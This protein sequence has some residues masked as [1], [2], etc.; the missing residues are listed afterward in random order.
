MSED[1]LMMIAMVTGAVLIVGHLAR[2]RRANLLQQTIREA[3]RH[4][5]SVAIA[6]LD[7]IDEQEPRSGSSDDRTGLVLIAIGA[8]LLCYALMSD[9]PREARDITAI[10]LFPLFVGAVLLARFAFLARRS[11]R[12]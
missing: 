9:I 12:P 10:A 1:V 6:L 5:T 11:Q 3:L 8:A 4:D 7:K 2:T